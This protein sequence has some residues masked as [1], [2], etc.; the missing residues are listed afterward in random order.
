MD[1]ITWPERPTCHDDDPAHRAP[2]FFPP[3]VW[4]EANE[5][6]FRTCSFC[7]S[8]HPEDLL[9]ALEAG[10]TLECADWKYG[11]PHKFYVRG[12]PSSDLQSAGFGWGKWYNA[13]LQELSP[14]A[15][16]ALAPRLSAGTGVTFARDERGI[17]WSGAPRG[18]L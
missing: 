18:V 10:A 2:F 8:I 3:P 4:R 15:F 1:A 5:H 9:R 17:K 13:H 12:V 6:G 7:G 14:E 16:D 11:W